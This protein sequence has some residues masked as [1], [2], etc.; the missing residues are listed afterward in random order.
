MSVQSAPPPYAR[1]VYWGLLLLGLLAALVA[2]STIGYI[3]H[4]YVTRE[5]LRNPPPQEQHEAGGL[6]SFAPSARSSLQPPTYA[7]NRLL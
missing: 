4:Q 2:F 5:E 1:T 3:A 6:P 7:P